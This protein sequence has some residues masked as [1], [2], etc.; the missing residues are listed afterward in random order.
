MDV[1]S[2]SHSTNS[3]ILITNDSDDDADSSQQTGDKTHRQSLSLK[4]TKKEHLTASN[5]N[6]RI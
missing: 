6:A 4:N 5:K 1:H 2:H 3:P